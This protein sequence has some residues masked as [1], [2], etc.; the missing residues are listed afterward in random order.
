MILLDG[1][2]LCVPTRTYIVLSRSFRR[3]NLKIKK[4]KFLLITVWYIVVTTQGKTPFLEG[5]QSLEGQGE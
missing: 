4:C 3:R 1:T 2:I 5:Y